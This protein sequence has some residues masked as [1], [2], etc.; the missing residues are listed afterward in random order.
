MS[1]TGN[2]TI[3]DNTIFDSIEIG[4]QQYPLA[5]TF[6]GE[7]IA[8]AFLQR[9]GLRTIDTY[10][11]EIMS[12]FREAGV[13]AKTKAEIGEDEYN[14]KSMELIGS[15]KTT[16]ISYVLWCLMLNEEN[17]FDLT[18]EKFL[19]LTFNL[20]RD[21]GIID[22]ANMVLHVYSKSKQQSKESREKKMK[23]PGTNQ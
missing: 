18:Y 1:T 7:N 17:I 23:T 13:L 6:G 14:M 10:I 22:L 4:G 21:Y 8:N 3:T 5:L 11:R 15:L 2:T 20:Y 16:S 19:K 9:N 12:F